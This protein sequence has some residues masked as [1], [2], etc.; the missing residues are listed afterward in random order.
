MPRQLVFLILFVA[1]LIGAALALA[2]MNVEQPL[3]PVEKPVIG[4]DLQ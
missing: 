2:S 4:D 1:I 3:H